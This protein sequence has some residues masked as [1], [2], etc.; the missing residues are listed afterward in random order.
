MFVVVLSAV[1]AFAE[2]S[3][4]QPNDNRTPAGSLKRGVL[5]LQLELRPGRWYPEDEKGRSW[6]S[7]HSLRK[8]T[9]PKVLV[10]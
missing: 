4:V 9:R 8:V 2:N 10:H 5:E 7:T 3:L 6:T 1:V